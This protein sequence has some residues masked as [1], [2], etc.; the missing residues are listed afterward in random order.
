MMTGNSTGA[1]GAV[2]LSVSATPT[3]SATPKQTDV[4]DVL[5]R[6]GDRPL[7]NPLHLLQLP[8]RHEAAGEG[9]VAEDDLDDDRDH[10]ERREMLRALRIPEVVLG[11]ADEAGGQAA[12]RVGQ[13]GSL[14]H[15]GE[16][17]PRERNAHGEPRA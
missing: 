6:I 8:G 15:G 13:R 3:T 17:H 5:K 2:G 14:R 4:G 9:Q 7:R 1:Q 12:E 16:R 11:R 10:P